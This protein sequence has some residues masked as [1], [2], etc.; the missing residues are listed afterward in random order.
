M[1]L[2]EHAPRFRKVPGA[3]L[4]FRRRLTRGCLL[5]HFSSFCR[6]TL[7]F[8]TLCSPS[9]VV[10]TL[11]RQSRRSEGQAAVRTGPRGSASG[12]AVSVPP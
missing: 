9:Q 12:S 11:K 6:S 10:H 2:V 1:F 8:P 5:P 7:E 4:R 3:A